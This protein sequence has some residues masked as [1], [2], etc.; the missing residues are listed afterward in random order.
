MYAIRSYYVPDGSTVVLNKGAKLE[1]GNNFNKN[2]TL[3][4]TG[5]AYF[6]VAKNESNPFVINVGTS[7]VKVLGTRNNFV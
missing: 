3:E 4:L 1:Y 7:K 5:E 6:N 2:R